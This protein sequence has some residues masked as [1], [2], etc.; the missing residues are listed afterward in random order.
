MFFDRL[1]DPFRGKAV[2]IPPMDGALKPNTALDEAAALLA[3]EAPDN[4]VAV[5]GRLHFS[6]GGALLA[7]PIGQ[8]WAPPQTVARFD[9]AVTA[10]TA[11][12]DGGLAIGLDDGRIL[13]QGGALDGREIKSIGPERLVCP[14][15]LAMP[16]QG[17]ILV[18][19]GSARHRPSD[20]VMDL[21]EK[22]STG[23][24][25]RIDLETGTETCLDRELGWPS[26]ILVERD[27]RLVVAEAWRHRLLRLF[28]DGRGQAQPVLAKLPGYP[29]RLSP[30]A[31]GGAWL[32]LFAPRNRLIEFVLLE[33]D[34][35]NDMMREVARDHWI[36][37][38]LSSGASFLEPLQCGSVR[39][40]GVRKPWAPSRS[41][42]LVVRLDDELQPVESFHSRAN[43]TRHGVTSVIENEGRVL[44]ASKGGNAILGLDPTSGN[45]RAAS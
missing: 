44:A 6:S 3:A 21:M 37:P 25:W 9:C 10:L 17:G 43:G 23:S 30:A 20:W 4:L 8:W 12:P 28:P 7:V 40:M 38:S 45:G 2:T 39:T 5:K 16:H 41:Y 42:G 26:G 35:R 22:G 29:A 24:V 36:A 15:A 11:T 31:D 33:D 13:F 34:Y 14:T 18:A 19:Q 1:L 27:H 32:A